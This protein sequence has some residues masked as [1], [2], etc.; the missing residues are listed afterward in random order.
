MEKGGG[1]CFWDPRSKR[2]PNIL[3]KIEGEER[4]KFIDILVEAS[5]LKNLGQPKT[6]MANDASRAL[7][8]IGP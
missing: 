1:A 2:R 6:P 8:Q 4:R 5:I 3:R 7:K